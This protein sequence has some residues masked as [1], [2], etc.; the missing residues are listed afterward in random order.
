MATLGY[1]RQGRATAIVTPRSSNNAVQPYDA[2]SRLH[3]R[4]ESNP[5][6]EV[7][8][9]PSFEMR[10][11]SLYGML[12]GV[13]SKRCKQGG[14]AVVR[15]TRFIAV[16]VALLLG[17]AVLLVVGGSGVRAETSHEKQGHNEATKE[18]EHRC[19]IWRNGTRRRGTRT[20]VRDGESY[21]TNDVPGCPKKGGRFSDTGS[22]CG[23]T[24][25]G[26]K[27]DDEISGSSISDELLG[28][29][30]KDYLTG[31]KEDDVLY[32]GDGDDY[33]VGGWVM[34]PSMEVMVTITSTPG[35][36]RWVRRG[37]NSIVVLAGTHTVLTRATMCRAVARM[38]GS[39]TPVA[40]P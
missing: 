35:T 17:C 2:G 8:I 12:R 25:A 9:T 7:G 26:K 30:G 27:G 32:G 16:V 34:M 10:L 6:V 33:L 15:Q 14:C 18:Q 22:S 40:L 20:I 29:P 4:G 39:K 19:G 31:Q 37:T 1:A 11:A 13:S 21:L 5:Y 28:G 36:T 3:L 23:C 24:L 38:T